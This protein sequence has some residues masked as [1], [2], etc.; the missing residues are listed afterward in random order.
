MSLDSGHS[1]PPTGDVRLLL[2]QLSSYTHLAVIFSNT[3]LQNIP[4][5]KLLGYR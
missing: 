4:Y 5:T 1:V 3:S 2:D